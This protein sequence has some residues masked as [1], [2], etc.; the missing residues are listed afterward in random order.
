LPE[1]A[2]DLV[3]LKVAV[4]ITVGGVP[5]ALAAKGATSTIPVVYAAAYEPDRAGLLASFNRPSGNVT[6]MSLFAAGLGGKSIEL[7]KELVPTAA[8]IAY[9]VNPS[10]PTAEIYTKEAATAASALGIQVPVL[11]ASTERDLEEA[12]SALARLGAGGLIVS[13]NRSS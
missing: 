9:L 11:S 2:A 1:L 3:S 10:N 6:G 5:A 13:G 7:L 12:F 4:L 8:V